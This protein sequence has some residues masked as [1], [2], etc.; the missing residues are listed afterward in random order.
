MMKDAKISWA[1]PIMLV[2]YET[3][4]YLANDMYLPALPR[5]ADDF[6]ISQ[7]MAQWTLMLWFIGAASMQLVLGPI[8]DRVGRRPIMLIAP[9]LFV[10]AT[11]VCGFTTDIYAMYVARF[12][13]GM[14][15]CAVGVAGYA[16]IHET[17]DTRRAIQ[18]LSIMGSITLLA[19]S[20]G[21]YLGAVTIQFLDYQWI[22]H[23][24]AILGLLS[25]FGLLYAMPETKLDKDKLVMGSILKDYWAILSHPKFFFITTT[26]CLHFVVFII[27]IVESPFIIQET[28]HHS[29]MHYGLIQLIIFS[30]IMIGSQFLRFLIVRFT[31]YQMINLGLTISFIGGLG[32][33]LT[34]FYY[35]ESLYLS[36]AWMMLLA[37]GSSFAFGP[38]NRAAVDS[39][40]LPMGKRMAVFSTLSG[41]AAVAGTALVTTFNDAT[42]NNLSLLIFVPTC[43]CSALWFMGRRFFKE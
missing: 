4:A 29:E 26:F 22:F 40:K 28:Y 42:L 36:V 1:F 31:S 6:N 18:I 33:F 23:I 21:P 34:N 39:I 16:A 11:L 30:Q 14:C 24:L 7:D 2:I 13:Q 37:F 17:Y 8:S 19:P 10:L 25:F 41:L 20:L 12:V 38:L 15:V 9:L 32:L 43:L 27:W 3:A 5:I 35:Q